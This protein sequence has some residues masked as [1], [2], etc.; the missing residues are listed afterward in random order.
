M[1]PTRWTAEPEPTMPPHGLAPCHTP[2]TKPNACAIAAHIA[3]TQGTTE[4]GG[5]W[6]GWR[7]AGRYLVTPDG[8]R[9]LPERLRGIAW[10]QDAEA[11]RDEARA[12]N[13]ARKGTALVRVVV[14]TLRE[15]QTQRIGAA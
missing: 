4:L 2:G 13:D 7:I 15:F 11:R 12:R 9:I 6:A 10:R 1:T 5:P 3:R 8:V 14:V